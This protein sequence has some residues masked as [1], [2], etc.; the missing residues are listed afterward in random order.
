MHAIMMPNYIKANQLSAIIAEMKNDKNRNYVNVSDEY[1]IIWNQFTFFYT[2]NGQ[3]YFDKICEKK[4]SR[5]IDM[6]LVTVR[7]GQVKKLG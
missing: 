2:E 7:L 6:D 5:T 1:L 4:I 3:I